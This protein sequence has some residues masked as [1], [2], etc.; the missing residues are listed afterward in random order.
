[1]KKFSDGK[2]TLQ[3]GKQHTEVIMVDNCVWWDY[4]FF[5]LLFV[6]NLDKC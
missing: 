1:M 2:W 4:G 3:K 5:F 6:K